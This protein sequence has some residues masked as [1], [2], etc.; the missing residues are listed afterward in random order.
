MPAPASKPPLLAI[1]GPTG[2]GK[3]ALAVVLARHFRGE[4][5]N[6]DSG[7]VYRGLDIG[8]AKPP[9]QVRQEIPHHLY[10]LV[11]PDEPFSLG[12]YVRL[13]RETIAD[14][15]SRGALPILVGA[16]GQYVWALLEGW[17]VPE[18][19][20][21]P[22]LRAALLAKA[23]LEG[24]DALYALLQ[25]L[26]PHA[27]QHIDSRN[28]RRVVRALEVCLTS[29]KPFSALRRRGEVPWRWL[30][31][32][33]TYPTRQALYQALDQRV[34][35][36]L[37]GGWLEEIRGLLAQGYSPD[38]PVLARLGYRPVMLAVQG[39][40]S[41]EEAVAQ[42]KRLHRVVARRAYTWFR[43]DDPRIR[44]LVVSPELAQ[45]AQDVVRTFLGQ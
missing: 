31:L 15:H 43:P 32:G 37:E 25:R 23:Q 29:G 22:S 9:P 16:S 19:P 26:D 13:A 24:P 34:E 36:M 7:Q 4:I 38:L 44:W 39:R 33:L 35:A 8:T 10:D 30:A 1:V 42:V 12:L 5:V 3:S 21:Q 41:L 14:I 20:P 18:V 11:N 28:L 2:T 45:Q 40:M 27:A 17:E 6:A